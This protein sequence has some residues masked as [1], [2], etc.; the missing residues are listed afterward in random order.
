VKPIVAR[1]NEPELAAG[2]RK[3]PDGEAFLGDLNAALAAFEDERYAALEETLPTLHVIGAPRSG[4]TLLHQV[5]SSGL[6]VGSVTNLVAAFW[7]APVTGLR[8]ARSLG[9]HRV[10]S[11]F[12]STFGRTRG[13]VEPHEFGYFWNH[14]L[15]Y[16]DLAE[17]APEHAD[18]IDWERLALIIRNMAAAAGAPFVFKPM[19]L[20]WHLER[21]VEVMPRTCYVWIRRDRRATA[22]SLLGMRRS[23]FGADDVWASL[24]P[25]EALDDE[26]PWRQVAAQ[27]V[28][29]ERTIAAAVRR[30][31]PDRVLEST[32]E[33]LCGDPVGVLEKV[34]T[35][36]GRHGCAPDL[37][38]PSL[39]PFSPDP[40]DALEREFGDRI[41]AAIA[42][43]EDLYGA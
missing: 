16:P 34:R 33:E 10:D 2:F 7:R 9:A 40:S 18:T 30:L 22:T 35:L 36:M 27:V 38:T 23:V 25:R 20:T 3:D 15:R 42:H 14:H 11:A 26:P 41:E 5:V 31:G 39:A 12:D 1:P 19:L 37:V 6:D 17:R 21:M 29:L 28:L 43:F 24:Q 8:L 4:T 13:I 32:Y